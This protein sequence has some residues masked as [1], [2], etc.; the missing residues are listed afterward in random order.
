[1][2]VLVLHSLEHEI[3]PELECADLAVR[4]VPAVVLREE[5]ETVP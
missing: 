1:V 2:L 5:R 4:V 3:E